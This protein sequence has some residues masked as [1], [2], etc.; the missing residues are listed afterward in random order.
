MV[1][2]TTSELLIKSVVGLIHYESIRH[3]TLQ[4]RIS[5][6]LVEVFQCVDHLPLHVYLCIRY[7]SLGS[8]T[9]YEG[10]TWE[11]FMDD[12]TWPLNITRI[13]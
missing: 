1:H 2:D 8:N 10:I 3:T 9:M 7:W 13:K 11:L 5:L 6:I 4:I 12:L